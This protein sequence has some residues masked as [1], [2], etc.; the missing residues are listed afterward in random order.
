MVQFQI[1]G[2]IAIAPPFENR[3]SETQSSKS[4]FQIPTVQYTLTINF[5][6]LFY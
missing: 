2:T 6:L 4:L 3:P 1:V 5:L